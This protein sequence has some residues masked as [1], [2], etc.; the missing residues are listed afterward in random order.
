MGSKTSLEPERINQNSPPTLRSRHPQ[1][2]FTSCGQRITQHQSDIFNT[3]VR[4]NLCAEAPAHHRGLGPQRQYFTCN[5]WL[6]A[7]WGVGGGVG[8]GSGPAR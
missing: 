4:Q 6:F 3:H 8:M 7:F 1:R 5:Y 2:W